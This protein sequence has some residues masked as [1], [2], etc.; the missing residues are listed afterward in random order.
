MNYIYWMLRSDR[1]LLARPKNK[2]HYSLQER[3]EFFPQYNKKIL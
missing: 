3:A 1:E 2:E